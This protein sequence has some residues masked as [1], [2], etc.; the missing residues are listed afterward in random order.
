MQMKIEKNFD[1]IIVGGSYAGLAAAMALGR[2]M[3]NVLIIDDGNP[4]NKQTPHS[5]NFLTNDGK[6]PAEVEKYGE[7]YFSMLGVA[8]E[9]DPLT[10][11]RALPWEKI[12]E[13]EQAMN[14]ELGKEYLFMGPWKQIEDGWFLPD[15]ILECF[16]TGNRNQVPFMV[17]ANMGELTGPAMLIAD[18]LVSNYVAMLDGK[19][20][21]D[22]K[23]YAIVFDQVPLTWRQE[24]CVAAHGME[25][26]YVFG[27]LDVTE[28][29]EAHYGGFALSGAKSPIPSVSANDRKIAEA[30]MNIWTRFA[31]TG[32]PG[33]EGAVEVPAWDKSGDRY[34]YL[35]ESLQ[36][37]TGYSALSKIKPKRIGMTL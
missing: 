22:A 27:S 28:A 37:K 20:G 18:T 3:K 33:P 23:G 12:V 35:N 29:W 10:A 2:A 6:T 14:V 34:L 8:G 36:A 26:H 32:V 15:S 19:A 24:G 17:V 16:R 11:A 4:C 25:L 30:M 5:H 9:K 13:V 7:R 21:Q 1:V 31:K